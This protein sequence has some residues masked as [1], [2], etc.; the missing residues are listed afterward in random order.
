MLLNKGGFKLHKWCANNLQ[1]L[2]D[3]E[4]QLSFEDNY[5]NPLGLLWDPVTDNFLFRVKHMANNGVPT[6][7]EVLDCRLFDPLGILGPIVVLAKIVL[8]QFWRKGID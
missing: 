5:V 4:K 8:Q 6:K 3:R 2:E 7:R 1:I